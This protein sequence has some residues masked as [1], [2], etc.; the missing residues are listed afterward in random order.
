MGSLLDKALK[1]KEESKKTPDSQDD[2]IL[3]E[4]IFAER[5]VK[6]GKTIPPEE[7]TPGDE[8]QKCAQA[9]ISKSDHLVDQDVSAPKPSEKVPFSNDVSEK[10][11]DAFG[12]S[13]ALIDKSI[14][15][16]VNE[17]ILK[18]LRIGITHE[19]T[20]ENL[21]RYIITHN[22]KTKLYK[23]AD[24]FAD[25]DLSE[26]ERGLKYFY[27]IGDVRRDSNNWYY[28]IGEK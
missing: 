13:S 17:R 18:L 25:K 5:S 24:Y 23:L 10:T 19:F 6:I 22:G 28:W 1:M 7:I 8:D 9:H 11:E 14:N 27:S 2:K 16:V 12:S 26:I 20:L 15:E 4:E 3:P 21:K